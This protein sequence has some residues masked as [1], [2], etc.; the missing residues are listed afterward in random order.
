MPPDARKICQVDGCPYKTEENLMTIDWVQKDMD[1]Y[2]RWVHEILSIQ[3]NV[4]DRQ[5][6]GTIDKSMLAP[7][8]SEK[9]SLKDHIKGLKYWDTVITVMP[10]SQKQQHVLEILSKTPI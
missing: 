8:Y 10:G 1:Q 4:I 7:C 9:V 2:I 6:A 3:M 5:T